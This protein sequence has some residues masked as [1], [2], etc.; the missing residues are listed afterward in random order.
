MHRTHADFLGMSRRTRRIDGVLAL[1]VALVTCA[2]LLHCA[3]GGDGTGAAPDSG[4]S[5]DDGG[6]LSRLGDASACNGQPAAGCP[7]SH[8]NQSMACWT[9]DPSKRNVGSCRDGQQQCTQ[10]GE[11]AA[12]GPCLGEVLDC[13]DG[14]GTVAKCAP[15]QC[16]NVSDGHGGTLDCGQCVA[17]QTCGANNTCS[18]VPATCAN[19]GKNCG[20]LPDGCGGT[21]DCGTCSGNDVCGGGG[22]NNV[23]GPG[24][25]MKTTCAQQGAG[26]GVISDGCNSTLDCGA[27][28][29]PQVCGGGGIANQCGCM[30]TTCGAQG[31]GC[32]TIADGC[33]G[34]LSCGSCPASQT[35]GG[36]GIPN[37]CGC[38]PTTCG[39]HNATCGTIADGCGGTL[40]CGSCPASQTCGGG[41]TPNQCGGCV[42][43]T[44]GSLGLTC[45]SNVPDGCGGS[46]DCGGACTCGTLQLGVGENLVQNGCGLGQ[47]SQVVGSAS[48]CQTYCNGFSDTLCC[49]MVGSICYADAVIGDCQPPCWGNYMGGDPGALC[50]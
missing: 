41:G 8:V 28:T 24:P 40:S 37:Q 35:C 44:C 33:G 12:W 2:P 21:L 25:C 20:S 34:T 39:A 22:S 47:R 19:L 5:T 16:G 46:L 7:C 30:P 49:W 14:G 29:F 1:L 48:A 17:P 50:H 36:G 10:H 38:T 18:C 26:C 15:G 42:P 6:S 32:G 3:G 4:A 9:G 23:C 45:G 11:V 13:G 31:A 27:C 43:A